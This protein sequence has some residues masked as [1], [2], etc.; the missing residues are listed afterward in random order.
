[1]AQVARHGSRLIFAASADVSLSAAPQTARKDSSRPVPR[2]ARRAPCFAVALGERSRDSHR[3]V[4]TGPSPK[5][6]R[7]RT[8]RTTANGLRGFS[9]GGLIRFRAFAG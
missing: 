5:F 2:A 8:P 6:R 9:L 3:A 1:M 4:Q 7:A